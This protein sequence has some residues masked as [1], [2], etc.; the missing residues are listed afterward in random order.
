MKQK[1]SRLFGGLLCLCAVSAAAR[2][3]LFVNEDPWYFIGHRPAGERTVEG[4][5]RHIDRFAAGGQ[6]THLAF[7]VNGMRTM[8][9]S[10]VWEPFWRTVLPDGTVLEKKDHPMRRLFEQGIDPVAVWIARS[11]E[12]G[13]S[14]W[15]SMR[16]ND[17]H[18]IQSGNPW[19]SCAFWRAHPELRRRP[20]LDPVT[21]TNWCW[22]A[23]AF[24]F[25]KQEVRDYHFALFREIVDRY[26]ADGYELDTLRFWEHLTPGREKEEAPHL[27]SF[28]RMC[29]QYTQEKAKE[30][31]HPIRLSA[32]VMTRY[33]AARQFGYDAEAWAR[34]GL[35]DLL[36]VCNFFGTVDYDFA[37]DAWLAR[38]RAANPRV[39]VLPGA[40]DCFANEACR[41]DAAA[42]RGW[43]DTL[44]AQGAR[45]LYLYNT[46]YLT[47][48]TKAVIFGEGLSPETVRQGVRRYPRTH[49]DC[50]P[51]GTRTGRRFPVPC[52]QTRLI[53]VPL[54]TPPRAGDTVNVVVGLGQTEAPAPS[55]RLN[56]QVPLAAPLWEDNRATYGA[57]RHTK[58]VWRYAFPVS[59]VSPVSN[60]VEIA[61][62]P[63]AFAQTPVTWTELQ[64]HPA[65]P[66]A[67]PPAVLT[68]NED[69]SRFFSKLQPEEMTREGLNRFIDHVTV[70]QRVSRLVFCATASRASYASKAVE[71]VWADWPE[72]TEETPRWPANAKRLADA[73]IDPYVEWIHA[74]RRKGVS[75]WISV[76]LNDLHGCLQTNAFQLSTFWRTNN[77]FYRVPGTIPTERRGAWTDYALDYSHPEVRAYYLRLIEEVFARFDADGFELDFLRFSRHLTPGREREQ[78]PIMTEFVRSVRRAADAVG[79][80]RGRPIRLSVRIPEWYE[81]ARAFGLD[82]ETWCREGLVDE[83]VPHNMWAVSNFD[84][85]IDEW[86]ARLTAANGK[87]RVTP[88]T[89][90]SVN[91]ESGVQNLFDYAAYCGWADCMYSRGATNLYLFNMSYV[92]P[93]TQGD[94]YARGLAPETVR[95]HR[96]RYPLTYHDLAPDGVASGRILPVNTRTNC[97]FTIYCGRAFPAEKV[98]VLLGLTREEE[99]V[100]PRQVWLNGEAAEGKPVREKSVVGYGVKGRTKSLW[101]YT[102]P[103]TALRKGYNRVETGAMTEE[104]RINWVEID[105]T[106][107]CVPVRRTVPA[108]CRTLSEGDRI[109]YEEIFEPREVAAMPGQEASFTLCRLPDGRLRFYGWSWVDGT[110]R[111]AF[112]ESSNLGLDWSFSLAA[113]NDLQSA[114]LYDPEQRVSVGIDRERRGKGPFYC[115]RM[116][117]GAHAPVR[118]DLPF[119]LGNFT[120]IMRLRARPR[121]LV[122][123]TAMIPGRRGL[124]GAVLISDDAGETWR[125][126]VA[127]PNVSTGETLIDRDARVRWDNFCSEPAVAELSDGSLWMVVRT[128]YDHPYSYRSHDGG[129]TWT[130]PEEMRDFWQHSTMPGLLRLSDGRLLFL[131]NNTQAMPRLPAE[132]LPELREKERTTRGESVFTNRDVLH[133]AISEDDGRTWIGFRE[134]R[135]NRLRNA[136]DFRQTEW[137]R[138][139]MHDKSVHQMQMM[140]LPGGKVLV[141]SGQSDAL[142]RIFL[143]DVRWLYETSRTELFRH[144]F[145]FLSHHL[146]VKSLHGTFRGFSGHCALNRLPS[147]VMARKPETGE[148]TAREAAWLVKTDD[149]RIQWNEPGLTWNFPAAREGTLEIG[150]RIEGEGFRLGL[151][152]HWINPSDPYAKERCLAVVPV[153]RDLTGGNWTR[154]CVAWSCEQGKMTV[155]C[156]K[157]PPVTVDLTRRPRFGLSYLHIQALAEGAD[158]KGTFLTEFHMR[159]LKRE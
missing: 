141:T 155:T 129:E 111:K 9:P 62:L 93:E 51:K 113:S 6:V 122:P 18:F 53:P 60:A 112:L 86:Q 50:V 147:L 97:A 15:V 139:E 25:A 152:D 140:E 52:N 70:S 64:I 57:D 137:M 80:A 116:K 79:R 17:V 130:G 84:L 59:A 45:G 157:K 68:V 4:L 144:G 12:K 36:V 153:T 13:I 117:D 66:S 127:T 41:L 142:A 148:R 49:H 100:A 125:R 76:R 30:R 124:F 73:G 29:R 150:C 5:Q 35:I 131:W 27:T 20:D 55:V 133:A 110:R 154:L 72:I 56:G 44:Y 135:L 149:P 14:P 21:T 123:H 67:G 63:N 143:F 47:E 85:R 87:V 126:S 114:M 103:P 138:G 134:F 118:S 28:I 61:A 119:K 34:E 102:F 19:N 37:F 121:W 104:T 40:T 94:V 146:Y 48:N 10:N 98:C 69:N 42:Y 109:R 7:C 75:P 23:F 156:G 81:T 106:P 78:T 159:A 46:S 132:E 115:L 38:L 105:V 26:D 151:A 39:R 54:G 74:A 88:G 65:V 77:R 2:T 158:H 92:K 8:Y 31:G 43:A 96:R 108:E 83:V 101:R 58:S 120:A 82:P 16:V 11:R 128:S 90:F 32:R 99:S 22:T 91:G 3:P 24:N 136:S 95:R 1:L 107:E 145:D 33:E 89:D 71:P